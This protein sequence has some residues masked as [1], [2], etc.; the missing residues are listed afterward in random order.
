MAAPE[1]VVAGQAATSTSADFK[2]K[3]VSGVE[4]GGSS[5]CLA[6][7]RSCFLYRAPFLLFLPVHPKV[8]G[9]GIGSSKVL[10]LF[11]KFRICAIRKYQLPCPLPNDTSDV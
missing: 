7:S 4:E 3:Q 10:E 6:Q 2:R 1:K 5:M 9:L 8:S 11:C